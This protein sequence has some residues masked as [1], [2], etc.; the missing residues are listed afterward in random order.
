VRL[1]PRAYSPK[2]EGI[3]RQ[4]GSHYEVTR[5]DKAADVL[6][7]DVEFPDEAVVRLALLLDEIDSDWQHSISWPRATS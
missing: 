6:M 2:A 1:E 5:I 4:V 7:Q 3:I